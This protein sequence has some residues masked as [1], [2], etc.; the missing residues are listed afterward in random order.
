MAV[1][2]TVASAGE[3]QRQARLCAVE[4][5]LER[6]SADLA[7][8]RVEAATAQ[9]HADLLAARLARSETEGD[10][11]RALLTALQESRVHQY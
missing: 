11:C 2:L 7:E 8:V 6:A 10:E 4:T 1:A 5:Q 9:Q 3:K